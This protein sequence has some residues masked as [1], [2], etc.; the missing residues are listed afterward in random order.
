M[1]AKPSLPAKSSNAGAEP[2]SAVNASN[3]SKGLN[4]NKA[5][6]NANHVTNV[7]GKSIFNT[8]PNNGGNGN[9]NSYR[10]I[11]NANQAAKNA[12]TNKTN[13]VLTKEG[14]NN[15]NSNNLSPASPGTSVTGSAEGAPPTTGNASAMGSGSASTR[16]RSR[17]NRQ[18]CGGAKVKTPKRQKKTKGKK[19]MRK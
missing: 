11:N 16:R 3:S 17:K 9:S 13:I 6:G 5:S 8:S 1:G 18:Q 4:F 7:G 14:N 2:V 19:T 10:A 12:R 15:N